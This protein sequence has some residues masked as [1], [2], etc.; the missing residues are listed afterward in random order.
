M[1]VDY[2]KPWCEGGKEKNKIREIKKLRR[3]PELFIK[4]YKLKDDEINL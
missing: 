4:L 2:I 1:E 3:L